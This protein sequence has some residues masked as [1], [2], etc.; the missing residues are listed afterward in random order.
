MRLEFWSDPSKWPFDGL[1]FLF[2]G[3]AIDRVGRAEF[4]D[5]WNGEELVAD[6]SHIVPDSWADA[7][8][9]TKRYVNE[10]LG[11]HFH[12]YKPGVER[13]VV[14]QNASPNYRKQTIYIGAEDWARGAKLLDAQS[15]KVAAQILRRQAVEQIIAAKLA[16]GEFR[17]AARPV[18]GGELSPVP[19]AAWHTEMWRQRF[20]FCQMRLDKPFAPGSCGDRSAQD[21]YHLIFLSDADLTAFEKTQRAKAQNPA[22]RPAPESE[23]RKFFLNL[24]QEG[25]GLTQKDAER[26]L[27]KH[28]GPGSVPRDRGRAIYKEVYGAKPAGRPRSKR[29]TPE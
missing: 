12:D 7:S 27:E 18:R 23:V 21:P 6:A 26:E 14:V 28:F 2:L 24:K 16:A 8:F 29:P 11:A 3:R 22:H 20:D 13:W 25:R 1:G 17:A 5:K 9:A 10:S 4:G 19:A 15:R